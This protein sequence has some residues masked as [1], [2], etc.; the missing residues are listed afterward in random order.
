M[1]MQAGR[2]DALYKSSFDCWGKILKNEGG[3]AF[4]KGCFSNVFRGIGGA[5]VLVMYDELQKNFNS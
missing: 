4:F 5:V 2:T 1:M 3:R